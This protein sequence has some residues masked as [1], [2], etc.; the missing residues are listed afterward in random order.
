MPS[1]PLVLG[2]VDH[3]PGVGPEGGELVTAS[4]LFLL[5]MG[6]LD[7]MRARWWAR[8]EAGV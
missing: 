6:A 5:T 7:T 8:V 4:V 3:V 1:A 2:F